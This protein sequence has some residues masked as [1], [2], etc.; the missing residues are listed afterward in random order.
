MATVY[1][2]DN[3]KHERRVA[4]KV[5]KRFIVPWTMPWACCSTFT[6]GR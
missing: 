1:L 5:T 2:A 3:L 6:F 4:L